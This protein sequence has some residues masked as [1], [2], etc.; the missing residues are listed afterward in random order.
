MLDQQRPVDMLRHDVGRIL[1]T[2]HLAE[3]DGSGADLV[4]CPEICHV[5]VPDLAEP[6][7]PAHADRRR[8]VSVDSDLDFEAKVSR[9]GLQ[10]KA[11]LDALVDAME[12]GLSLGKC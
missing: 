1:S 11:L 10:P 3:L 8:G 9:Q 2:W 6:T 5:E 7:A 12:F 4:L